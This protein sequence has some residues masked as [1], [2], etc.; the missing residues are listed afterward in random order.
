MDGGGD[1]LL[2]KLLFSGAALSGIVPFALAVEAFAA[3][4]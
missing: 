1:A 2:F 3:L 4:L